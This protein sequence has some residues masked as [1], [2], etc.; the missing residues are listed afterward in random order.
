MRRI[1]K[2]PIEVLDEHQP[3]YPFDIDTAPAWFEDVRPAVDPK[4]KPAPT[5]ESYK[6][7]PR[8]YVLMG[9]AVLIVVVFVASVTVFTLILRGVG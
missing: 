4:D 2:D 8:N 7:T 6:V 1:H 5:D 9:I 3:V